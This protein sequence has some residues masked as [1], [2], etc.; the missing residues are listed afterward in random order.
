MC[1]TLVALGK[2]TADGS[3]IL[4]KNSDR[5]PNEAQYPV[6]IPR[7]QHSEERVRCTHIEIP[8]VP[9]TF[10]VLLSKPY[11]MWGCEMGSNEFGVVIGNEAVF[12]KEPKAETGLLGMD[13]IRLALERAETARRA[14]NVIVDLLQTYGQG[15][16][17]DLAG[18]LVYHNSFLI[19]DPHDAWVLETA[20]RYWAAKQVETLYSISNGLTIGTDWD[21]ASPGLVEHAVEKG[22]CTGESDF[23]FARCYSDFLYTRFSACRARRGVTMGHMKEG[24][25]SITVSD[26]ISYLR[27]HGTAETDAGWAPLRGLMSVCAHAAYP[28][29]RDSQTV[30]SLV[31]HL[32]EDMP[33]YWLTGT[34]A[35]CTG[36]FKPFAFAPLPDAVGRPEGT[37]DRQSLWWTH[38][39]L[40]RAVLADYE[41][42]MALYRQERDG[43]EASFVAAEHALYQRYRDAPAQEKRQAAVELGQLCFDQALHA[44][45]RWTERVYATP[46]KKKPG[47]LYRRYWHKQNREARFSGRCDG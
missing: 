27:D 3:V 42:R 20:G 14:V 36:L 22:W 46:V 44:T 32:R 30:A 26:M 40:H 1:D 37:F 8:Q 5:P 2:A 31:T 12:T 4:A 21:L 19:A 23:H 35:P 39:C 24:Q 18:K 6:Y 33:V 15:G 11:W 45:R 47:W 10:A 7:M 13:M 25:G 16:P 28:V 34:S 38:E 41:P 43:L 9:E 29:L 17:C